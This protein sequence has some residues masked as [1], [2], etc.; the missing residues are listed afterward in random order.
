M[1]TMRAAVAVV[2]FRFWPL[3]PVEEP[4]EGIALNAGAMGGA[5]AV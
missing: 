3:P 5:D 1:I 2:L 4:T